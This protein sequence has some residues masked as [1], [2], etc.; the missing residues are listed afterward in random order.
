MRSPSTCTWSPPLGPTHSASDLRPTLRSLSTGAGLGSKRQSQN[1]THIL[2]S[3][4]AKSGK[5]HDHSNT[6]VTEH[7]RKR[8]WTHFHKLQVP[9]R[10]RFLL[11]KFYQ[12]SKDRCVSF[13]QGLGDIQI[14]CWK[15][16]FYPSWN[17][18]II[19]SMREH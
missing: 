12:P 4:R 5:G 6:E 9:C 11:T 3:E 16:H 8:S 10:S 2:F 1:A 19:E 15:V 14:S 17:E 18:R 13:S 7:T